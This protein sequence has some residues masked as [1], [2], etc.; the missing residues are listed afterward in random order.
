M[1]DHIDP[2]NYL[3][4]LFGRFISDSE[5]LEHRKINYI[6]FAELVSGFAACGV[7]KSIEQFEVACSM[8][9]NL[10]KILDV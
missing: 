4:M 10:K 2:I 3:E 1:S 7:F 8:Q 6:A 5:L 9:D